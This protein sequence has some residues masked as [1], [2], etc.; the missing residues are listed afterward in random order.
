MGK[1]RG[2]KKEKPVPEY[3]TKEERQAEI[4][5]ILSKLSELQLNPRYDEIREL[6]EKIQLYIAT[7]DRIEINI[8][9]FAIKKRIVGVL[10]INKKEQVWV[11]LKNE[12]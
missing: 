1:R 4:K 5:P 7:G 10:S 3:R 8:P 6:Y 9:F 2:G 12:K 11:M